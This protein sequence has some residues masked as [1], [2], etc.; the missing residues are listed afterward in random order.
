MLALV[1]FFQEWITIKAFGQTISYSGWSAIQNGAL[2]PYFEL[3][4]AFFG[5]LAA[6][7]LL[8]RP[9]PYLRL[10]LMITGMFVLIGVGLGTAA[11]E[12]EQAFEFESFG[13]LVGWGWGSILT[14]VGGVMLLISSLGVEH[15][16]TAY[17]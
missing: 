17:Y 3:L 15:I 14:M 11:L 1:G 8:V 16:A 2:T 13:I 5:L 10:L 7:L 6:F 12:L 4:G 9:R